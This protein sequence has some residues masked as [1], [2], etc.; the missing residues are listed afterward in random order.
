MQFPRQLGDLRHALY[1]RRSTATHGLQWAMTAHLGRLLLSLLLMML[2]LTGLA[3]VV[4]NRAL[5]RIQSEAASEGGYLINN[6]TRELRLV[7]DGKTLLQGQLSGLGTLRAQIPT[8]AELDLRLTSQ[9]ERLDLTALLNKRVNRQVS[10]LARVTGFSAGEARIL[11]SEIAISARFG[12]K[13]QGRIL[14]RAEQSWRANLAAKAIPQA[15]DGR[16]ALRLQLSKLEIK[17]FFPGLLPRAEARAKQR[18]DRLIYPRLSL[19]HG[20][21][22][23][24]ARI[25]K[26]ALVLRLSY[27]HASRPWFCPDSALAC[28]A[29][30]LAAAGS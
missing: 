15:R 18:L 3:G 17:D 23:V 24:Q 29:L 4:A 12:I 25:D 26:G 5:A 7:E 2:V 8:H 1:H 6:I 9:P 27:Q 11:D 19:P 14:K 20:W 13:A 22:V 28:A 21:Q 10:G 16:L 30:R